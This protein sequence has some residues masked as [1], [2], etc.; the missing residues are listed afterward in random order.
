MGNPISAQQSNTQLLCKLCCALAS[1]H[2]HTYTPISLAIEEEEAKFSAGI[3]NRLTNIPN[4]SSRYYLA[5]NISALKIFMTNCVPKYGMNMESRK[6][7]NSVFHI[8]G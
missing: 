5:W 8:H 1:K 2:T 3:D 4:H 7:T 6:H